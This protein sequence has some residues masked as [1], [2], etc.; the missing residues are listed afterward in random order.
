M[1]KWIL[2]IYENFRWLNWAW[3]GNSCV[4]DIQFSWFWIVKRSPF[5]SIKCVSLYLNILLKQKRSSVRRLRK[6][7]P[8]RMKSMEQPFGTGPNWKCSNSISIDK[9]FSI[10]RKKRSIILIQPGF[11][12]FIDTEILCFLNIKIQNWRSQISGLSLRPSRFETLHKTDSPRKAH[13]W[14]I[15]CYFHLAKRWPS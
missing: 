9:A 4:P 1:K 13:F 6:T 7:H 14:W 11:Q 12:F 2:K 15:W 3:L 8:V 10:G 5:S